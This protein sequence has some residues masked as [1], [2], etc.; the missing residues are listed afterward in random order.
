MRLL[1]FLVVMVRRE[2]RQLARDPVALILTLVAPVA[3]AA[4]ASAA[5]GSPPRV[6]A[7]V[8]GV[9][10]DLRLGD[11]SVLI[12]MLP[13]AADADGTLA[14]EIVADEQR[15]RDMVEAGHAEA[16]VILPPIGAPAGSP[17]KVVANR[18][19]ELVAELASSGAEALTMRVR[20]VAALEAAGI[21]S[22]PGIGPI[23]VRLV[24]PDREPLSGT[25]LYGPAIAVFFMFLTAG[26]VARGLQE[27]RTLGTLGRLRT[28]PIG[29]ATIVTAKVVTMLIVA[30]VEFATVFVTIGI[31]S[32]AQ[33]GNLGAIAA[34]ALALALVVGALAL[35]IASFAATAIGLHALEAGVAFGFAALGGYIVPLQNLPDAARTVAAAL[36]N[37]IA[38]GAMRDITANDAGGGDVTAAVLL[39]LV[40]AGVF[41]GIGYARV[42]RVVEA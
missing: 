6:E 15:A 33:W 29:S 25:E 40:F 3:A 23:E 31:F 42:R 13:A 20:A 37:G 30:C 2:L 4:I 19:A 17:I 14:W 22:V 24:S 32:D 1:R 10:S 16:A 27:E 39:I 11:L 21:A 36:P 8:V 12:D 5:F 34:V 18:N 35:L 7:T 28:I 9:A 41:G 38:I 26:F